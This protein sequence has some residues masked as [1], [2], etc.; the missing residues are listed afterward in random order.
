MSVIRVPLSEPRYSTI[1][2]APGQPTF[3]R[4]LWERTPKMPSIDTDNP[5]SSTHSRTRQSQSRRDSSVISVPSYQQSSPTHSRPASSETPLTP[6]ESPPFRSSTKRNAE[7]LGED[8]LNSSPSHSRE[9][10]GDSAINFCLCQPEPK[11]PRPR[12]GKCL[13]WS[14]STRRC[15]YPYKTR[16]LTDFVQ[17]LFFTAR[18]TKH[19]SLLTIQALPTPTSQR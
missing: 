6:E 5:S 18:T 1:G 15:F 7:V 9:P 4:C 12:N 3:H 2:S 19:R 16:Q 11:V 13:W 8:E 17:L 14:T 10:S